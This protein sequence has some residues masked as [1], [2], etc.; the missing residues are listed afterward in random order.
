M[1]VPGSVPFASFSRALQ[2]S[3]SLKKLWR[4]QG[5]IGTLGGAAVLPAVL[6]KPGRSD[7]QR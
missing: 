3:A 2:V 1:R 7:W 4:G 5:T 6:T